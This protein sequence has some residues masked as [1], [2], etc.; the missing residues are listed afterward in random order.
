MHE[1][2]N[3]EPEIKRNI[4]QES[5]YKLKNFTLQFVSEYGDTDV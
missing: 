1:G 4:N 2:Y 5:N 3:L